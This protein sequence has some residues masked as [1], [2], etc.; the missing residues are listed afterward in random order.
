MPPEPTNP[1]IRVHRP[2]TSPAH[3]RL[4]AR[5]AAGGPGEAG[6]YAGGPDDPAIELLEYE[7]PDLPPLPTIKDAITRNRVSHGISYLLP[8]DKGRNS[9]NNRFRT[10]LRAMFQEPYASDDLQ[11]DDNRVALSSKVHFLSNTGDTKWTREHLNSIPIS[12]NADSEQM[13][14]LYA[15]SAP[16]GG[17]ASR[18]MGIHPH[19]LRTRSNL[20]LPLKANMPPELVKLRKEVEDIIK[21]VKEDDEDFDEQKLMKENALLQTQ[22]TIRLGDTL[23]TDSQLQTQST[24][25]LGD[26]LGTD[27]QL[28]PPNQSH[29][30]PSDSEAVRVRPGGGHHL[31]R[32]E[33]M[34]TSLG[35]NSLAAKLKSIQVSPQKF[36]SYDELKASKPPK[37]KIPES[38]KSQYLDEDR[39]QKIWDWLHYGEEMNDFDFFLSVCG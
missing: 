29:R 36:N 6:A 35:T 31:K 12:L 11:Y 3:P 22:S 17:T 1:S 38:I 33:H 14:R 2:R 27:S 24:I 37:P 20:Y 39:N 25:R 21:S 23:G 7:W 26:T 30:M 18:R 16:T 15:H 13:R 9:I 8:V 34:L 19:K 5:Q 32:D 10:D 28:Q 4:T